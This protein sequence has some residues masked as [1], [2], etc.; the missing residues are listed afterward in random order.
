MKK[1]IL[2]VSTFILSLAFYGCSSNEVNEVEE[3]QIEEVVTEEVEE[4]I[5]DVVDDVT[6]EATTVKKEVKKETKS[7]EEK[8]REIK[9]EVE[10]EAI[11]KLNK[12]K[13]KTESKLEVS[14]ED[15]KKAAEKKEAEEN[16][17]NRQSTKGKGGF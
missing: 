17:L 11:D 10:K 8:A 13:G 3:P 14:G 7:V 12:G 9:E 2:F 6:K 4:D 1:K 5:T 15:V 16:I